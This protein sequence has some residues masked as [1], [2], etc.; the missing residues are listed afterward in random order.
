MLGASSAH[1]LEKSD[2]EW[3]TEAGFLA[4]YHDNYFFR[5]EKPTPD[6]TFLTLYG[7][8]RFAYDTGPGDLLLEA[9]GVGAFGL[10][11]RKTDFQIVQ[12]GIGYKQ[13]R[14]KTMASYRRTFD[15]VFGEEDDASL[16]DV[17]SLE[18]NLRQTF[19]DSLRGQ[20]EFQFQ[21][22]DFEKADNDR[23]AYRYQPQGLLRWEIWNFLALRTSFFWTWKDAEAGRYDYDGPGFSVAAEIKPVDPVEVFVRY[24]RRWRD[25]DNAKSGDSNFNRNDEIDD[26]IANARW[27]LLDWFGLR[28]EGMYRHGSST[29]SDRNY[30]AFSVTGGFFVTFGNES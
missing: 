30:D 21:N 18:V 26:V 19:I 2:W 6:E 17:D 4:G 10:E 14:T 27:K 12:G 15:K 28:L 5:G 23:D 7:I 20:I 1:A 25:Y 9:G 3:E 24:R 8:G 11:L 29:R 13:G 16:F 22:W